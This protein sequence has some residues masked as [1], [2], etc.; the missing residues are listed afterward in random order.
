LP[1]RLRRKRTRDA[2][3]NSATAPPGPGTIVVQA[4]KTRSALTSRCSSAT[5]E[6]SS[7]SVGMGL[8]SPLGDVSQLTAEMIDVGEMAPVLAER[9]SGFAP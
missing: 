5:G 4:L 8:E 7:F 6:Q 9:S 1:Q 2:V 3:A